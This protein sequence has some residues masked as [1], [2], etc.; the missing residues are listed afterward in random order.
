MPRPVSKTVPSHCR[1]PTPTETTCLAAPVVWAWGPWR[2]HSI[3]LHQHRPWACSPTIATDARALECSRHCSD[4]WEVGWNRWRVRRHPVQVTKRSM[5]HPIPECLFHSTLH[6][7]DLPPTQ[8]FPSTSC[9][10]PSPDYPSIE[11]TN[12]PSVRP[13]TQHRLYSQTLATSQSLVQYQR[14]ISF[15][16]WMPRMSNRTP[17]LQFDCRVHKAGTST[18]DPVKCI[19]VTGRI[20][21]V[22]HA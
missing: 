3:Q 20:A 12:S 8:T 18:T 6:A 21:L 2:F 7:I 17:L 5:L 19:Y 13:S 10:S 9:G 16:I 14:P 4:L 1:R 11:Y 22:C 15:I